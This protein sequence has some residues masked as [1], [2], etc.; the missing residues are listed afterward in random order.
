MNSY[1]IKNHEGIYSVYGENNC[2][3][4]R[5]WTD[6]KWG[7]AKTIAINTKGSF[8]LMRNNKGEPLILYRDK[9]GNLMLAN[10]DK[11]HKMVL[12]NNSEPKT[13]LHIDGIIR[14][15]TIRL[16]Y[17]RDYLNE[18]Y[19]TEQHRRDDGSW[20]NPI[21][22][23]SYIPDDKMTRL[24]S[25]GSNYILFYSKK[26]PEQQIGYREISPFGIREF[27]MLYATGYKIQDYS[28]A[29]T[30]EEIH[31]TAVISTARTSKLIYLKKDNSGI[32]KA[33]ILFE[34]GVKGCHI[35]IENSKIIILINTAK[36]NC[37][38]T[39]YDMGISFKRMENADQFVFNKSVFADYTRQIA[40]NFVA[41]ELLTDCSF[42]YEVRLCPIIPCN[43]ENEVEKLKKEIERL[44]KLH[45]N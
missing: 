6:C 27:K 10:R 19:L 44:K 9:D 3:Y 20:S 34:G 24:V 12:R 8:S 41:S 7:K 1:I 33:K 28:L 29:V 32:S 23:D 13:I 45:P 35:S 43:N 2:I 16:F 36:G 38:F 18:S 21:T 14:D 26:V 40:D 4:E 25:L 37:R 22:L 15:N 30:E 17:N 39:S 11:P 5:E 31:L 42:P